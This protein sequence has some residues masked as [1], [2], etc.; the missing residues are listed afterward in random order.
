MAQLFIPAAVV[1]L[2]LA[3]TS[4]RTRSFTASEY[5]IADWYRQAHRDIKDAGISQGTLKTQ[6]LNLTNLNEAWKPRTAPRQTPT[7]NVDDVYRDQSA[8][9]SYMEEYAHPFYFMRSG[10]I[11]LGSSEQSNPNVE[12]PLRGVSIKGDP[13]NSL[14]YYPRVYWDYDNEEK[15]PWLFTGDR[16]VMAAGEPE[17]MEERRV[18]PEGY[19]NRNQ[20]PWGPGGV[21][22]RLHNGVNERVSR[23]K[24]C[25]RS[26][27]VRPPYGS[28][29]WSKYAH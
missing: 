2:G 18:P 25:D 28:F 6:N 3:M 19:L 10:E 7:H 17:E 23:V 29:I 4:D 20:N 22:Q 11:P 16:R 8:I 12:I 24:H 9:I 27:V 15:N 14:A 26:E 5:E 21:V 13:N 1:A